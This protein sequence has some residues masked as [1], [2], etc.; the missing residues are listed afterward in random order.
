[1]EVE[2]GQDNGTPLLHVIVVIT[3][4]LSERQVQLM[5]LQVK[6]YHLHGVY[7]SPMLMAILSIG[8]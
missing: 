2:I 3:L 1:M 7:Q 8:R 4:Q 6:N 5:A